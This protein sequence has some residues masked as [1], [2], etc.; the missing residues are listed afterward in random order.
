MAGKVKIRIFVLYVFVVS[1]NLKFSKGLF[2]KA[3]YMITYGV[4]NIFI[5]ISAP[6]FFQQVYSH[7]VS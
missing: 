1:G 4:K 7:L 3:S 5:L 2:V 6:I